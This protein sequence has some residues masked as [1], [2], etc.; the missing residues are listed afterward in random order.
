MEVMDKTAYGM[1]KE[2]SCREW[3][4]DRN[5][6]VS[7]QGSRMPYWDVFRVQVSKDVKGCL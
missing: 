4:D 3:T 7:V 6:A 1:L 5:V 2:S